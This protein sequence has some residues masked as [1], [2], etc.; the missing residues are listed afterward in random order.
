MSL[1]IV[2]PSR[3]HSSPRRGNVAAMGHVHWG[4]FDVI[5]TATAM[6]LRW[7]LPLGPEQTLDPATAAKLDAAATALASR[8]AKRLPSAEVGAMLLRLVDG[9]GR[10]FAQ[11]VK[12]ARQQGNPPS[13]VVRLIDERPDAE[14][15]PHPASAWPWHLLAATERQLLTGPDK[16]QL[17]V[18]LGDRDV[19]QPWPLPQGGLRILFMAYSPEDT[20]RVLDYEAEEDRVLQALAPLVESGR[21]RVRV[22]EMGSVDELRRELL[23]RS[24]DIVHLSGHGMVRN[25]APQLLMEDAEGRRDNV[26]AEQLLKALRS[27]K[28]AP[29]LVMVSSC[30]SAEAAADMTSLAAALVQGGISTAAG[31]TRTVRD[32][33]ATLAAVTIYERLGA[34]A[35]SGEAL[36][37]ARQVLVAAE[38]GDPHKSNTWDSLA[39]VTRDG[40]GF[41]LDRH[42]PTLEDAFDSKQTYR[43]LGAGEMRVLRSGFVGRRR[44]LQWLITILRHGEFRGQARAGALIVG[45]KGVGK[46]CLAARALD[47]H[48]QDFDQP[49]EVGL[50]I[51]VGKLDDLKLLNQF[52]AVAQ[53][54]EDNR[55]LALLQDQ[56]PLPQRLARLFRHWESRPL[57]LV[58]DNFEDNLTIP[59]QGDAQ[60]SEEAAALLKTVLPVCLD[61]KP[62]LLITSTAKFELPAP[63]P[64]HALAIISLGPFDP[65]SRRKLWTRGQQTGELK[66]VA[67]ATWDALTERLGGNARVLDWAR[68]LMGHATPERRQQLLEE[69]GKAFPDWKAGTAPSAEQQ[70]ELAAAFLRHMSYDDAAA[71]MGPDARTFIQRARVYQQPVPAVAFTELCA[72]LS[73]DL[74]QHLPALQNLGLLEAGEWDK[75]PAYRVS[76]LVEPEYAAEEPARWHA[77]AARYWEGRADNGG[78]FEDVRQAWEHALAAGEQGIADKMAL[79]IRMTLYR[80]GLYLE[81]AACSEKHVA[82]FPASPVGRW[83]RGEMTRYAGG[84]L[85]DAVNDLREAERGFVALHG[86]EEHDDVATALHAL[87][88]VLQ[89]QGELPAARENL[90]RSL[91][92]KLKLYGT[93]EHPEVS[94]TLHALGGVLQAQGELPAAREKL[95]RSL[96]IKLKLYGTDEHPSVSATL[97]ELA[98]VLQAQGELPEAREKLERSLAIQLK[99]YG[100]DEH[101]S[102]S[103]TLHALAGVLQAQGELPEAREKLERSLAIKLKLYG[104]DEHPSVATTL[105]TLAGVL[106]AQGELPEAREKLERSLAIQLKLYGTDEHPSVSATLHA[107]GGVLQAQG[108]LPEAREKLERSLAI[109]MKLYGTD[110]HPS[111]ATTLHALAGVLQAQGELPEAREKLERSLAIK[112]KLYGTDEHP[113]VAATLHT[114]AGVLQAQGELPEAREKLERSLAIKL[115]LYGTDE[116]PSVSATLAELAGVLQAQGELPEAREKLERSLAIQLKLYG[117]DEHPSVS[118][119]LRALAGI[120]Q[121]EG[122]STE[123]VS[124]YRRVLRIEE[125]VFGSLDQYHSAE[126]EVSLAML[127]F[128][129]NR[130]EEAAPLLQHAIQVLRAQVPNHPIL[131]YIAKMRAPSE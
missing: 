36:A 121:T 94:V 3:P 110:E 29:S 93:D 65:A 113:S 28:D 125:K 117:T 87:G 43:Y 115:K 35:A 51:V 107:L 41:C 123:A 49:G 17:L 60:L 53:R 78:D 90:E 21:V 16:L 109:D 11:F 88:G 95:E 72:G 40:A 37:E 39:V 81:N 96:A 66:K 106:Q 1:S 25:G 74:A 45:N 104:T 57:V 52:T 59:T 34:G 92:I 32:D 71:R 83:W 26:S 14:D 42:K 4:T 70:D 62:K 10:A 129:L 63:G 85:T 19:T 15:T 130:P 84:R 97:A 8:S 7:R 105:H 47:R 13:L 30:H 111:V 112:L 100:T 44:P 122:R 12:A 73:L 80:R 46:S 82:R 50:A 126:T 118:A 33:H 131:K 64:Q 75:A 54:W 18:Q 116:H 20:E 61:S 69:A 23:R 103:A 58:L 102:V 67:P 77:A 98:G 6:R 108:E 86:T 24:F 76:P 128:E 38:R 56:A 89:A 31:W 48:T 101:P 124:T 9:P 5:A 119:T 127:L 91:A 99:L 120:L 55:A 27:G 114:L 2:I 79:G 22:A 68:T